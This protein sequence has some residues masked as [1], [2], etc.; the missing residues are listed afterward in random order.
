M[1]AERFDEQQ[2]RKAARS[3]PFR[4]RTFSNNS[5]SSPREAFPQARLKPSRVSGAFFER[6]FS[7]DS[8]RRFKPAAGSVPFGR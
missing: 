4:R 5:A 6:S 7:V 3:K 8:V 2:V 1:R